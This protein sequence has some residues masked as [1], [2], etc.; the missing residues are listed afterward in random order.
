[1]GNADSREYWRFFLTGLLPVFIFF[2]ATNPIFSQKT[3]RVISGLVT[4]KEEGHSLPG[5]LVYVKGTQN[6]S[7]TQQDGMYYIEVTGKDSVLVFSYDDCRTK[8]VR[9]SQSD[10]YNVSLEYGQPLPAEPVLPKNQLSPGGQIPPAQQPPFSP[11]GSWR[12]VFQVRPG[13]EVPVNFQIRATRGGDPEA[14]FLNA[15]EQFDGGRVKLAGDSLFIFLDQFDNELA[16][17]ITEGKL[18]GVLKRQ[19]NTGAVIPV[20]A[21]AGVT[22]RFPE[23]GPAP[24]GNLSGT[25][26]IVFKSDNGKE[27]KAVGLFRQD[28]NKLKGTFLRVTGDSRYLE[29]IVQGNDFYLSSFIGSGPSYYKGTFTS[30]GQLAGEIV[31]AHGGQ[32]F[33]G[34]LNATAALPDPY[35]LTY[36]KEGYTSFDF[37]LPD[38]AGRKIS[39]TDKKFKNKVVIVTIG[40]T[41]CPNCVDEASF[42]AP[43]YDI[44]HA[45]G[46]EIVSIQY[47]RQTD[48]EFV[49]KVL[50]RMRDKYHIKY[51]QVFGGLADKA[52]V[53]HSLPALNAFLAFPTTILIDKQGRVARIHTGYTG[54][55]T[56]AYYQQFLKEFNEEIDT[57]LKG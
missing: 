15:E 30:N 18:T 25:Y 48:P 45:R 4:S 32:G 3:S 7:G 43:W 5:V 29:G 38:P 8:E 55:A 6:F 11:I 21:L 53:A 1:M 13:V 28:G 10:N 44:N 17:R 39:L 9:L 37:S 26:D 33:T 56:G 20:D 52:G 40:G 16:F 14:Y 35:K 57:L 19:D 47:E 22:Y 51:D 42:L 31:G 12:A 24:A 46:V 54:P 41:W 34:S 49:K 2:S 36:L 27:E 50:T 23:T